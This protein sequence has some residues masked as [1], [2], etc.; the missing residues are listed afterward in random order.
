[1]SSSLLAGPLHDLARISD[2]MHGSPT[3]VA[4]TQA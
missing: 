3:D 1:M 2:T 4:V